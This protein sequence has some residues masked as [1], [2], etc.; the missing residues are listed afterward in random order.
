MMTIDWARWADSERGS[1]IAMIDGVT[2]CVPAEGG[3]RHYDAI[4]A[5]GVEIAEAEGE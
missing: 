3:N 5:S 2:M 4:L 1:L